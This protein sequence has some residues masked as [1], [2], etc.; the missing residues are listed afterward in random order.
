MLWGVVVFLFVV[1]VAVGM[2]F[3][4]EDECDSGWWLL[5]RVKLSIFLLIR[6]MEFSRALVVLIMVV[7]FIA[8]SCI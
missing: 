2:F 6:E 3:G 7:C 4:D 8:V 5:R 1:I